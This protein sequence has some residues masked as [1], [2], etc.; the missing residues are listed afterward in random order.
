MPTE[1]PKYMTSH[2]LAL[3]L[4]VTDASVHKW[5]MAGRLPPSRRFGKRRLH[6]AADAIRAVVENGLAIAPDR[7][8][9][10][11]SVAEREF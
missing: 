2:E 8:E 9:Q 11:L 4:G 10:V 6:N 5:A 1:L 7:L 3:F